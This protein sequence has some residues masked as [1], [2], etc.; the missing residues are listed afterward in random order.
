MNAPDRYT[1]RRVAND[2]VDMLID[3]CVSKKAILET[4]NEIGL[5]DWEFD[6]FDL[7]WLR[8]DE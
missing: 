2:L 6:Y 5:S 4:L 3:E 7:D 8:K 1:A